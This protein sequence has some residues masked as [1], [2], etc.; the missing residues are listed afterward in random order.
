[1]LPLSFLITYQALRLVN[2]TEQTSP[3]NA[4]TRHIE[5]EHIRGRAPINIEIQQSNTESVETIR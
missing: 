5:K 4:H 1:M 2:P 3:F